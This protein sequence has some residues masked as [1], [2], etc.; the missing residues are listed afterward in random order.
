ME[1]IKFGKFKIVLISLLVLI[2]ISSIVFYLISRDRNTEP[3][4]TKTKSS[5]FSIKEQKLAFLT[6][7]VKE[8]SDVYNAEYSIEYQNNNYGFVPGPSEWDI[9]VVLKVQPEKVS[10]WV[11]GFQEVSEEM[12]HFDW[13][14]ELDINE[15]E[16][17]RNSK[18]RFYKRKNQDVYIIV[19]E[20]EGIIF[21]K[22]TTN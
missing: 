8:Y 1:R 13:W 18:P 6:K 16:W 15:H 3:P 20:V 10:D 4:T 22:I 5:S 7:Y 17:N 14:G 9:R 12:V 19:Y 11:E 2:G 21:K